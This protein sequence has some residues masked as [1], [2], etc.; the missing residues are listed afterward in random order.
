MTPSTD[1]LTTHRTLGITRI[2]DAPRELVWRAWSEPERMKQWWGPKPFTA[3]AIEMDFHFGGKYLFCMRSP[4]G[5]DFWNTGVYTEIGEASRLTFTNCFSDEKAN[6]VSASY[7]GMDPNVALE[8][9]TDVKFEEEGGKTKL[10]IRH[11]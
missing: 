11:S 10:T 5:Q 3:P 7:Y 6:I 2:F 8:M 4:N 1:T 9:V